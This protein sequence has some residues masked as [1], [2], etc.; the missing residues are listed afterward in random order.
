MTSFKTLVTSNNTTQ[1]YNAIVSVAPNTTI[2]Q[3][4]DVGGK[5]AYLVGVCIYGDTT[6][7]GFDLQNSTSKDYDGVTADIGYVHPVLPIKYQAGGTAT[8]EACYY[9]ES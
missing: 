1:K 9:I 7:V 4:I 6:T 2:A 3:S 8:V 5:L